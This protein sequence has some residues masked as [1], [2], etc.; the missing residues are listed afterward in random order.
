MEILFFILG[1]IALIWL[2]FISRIKARGKQVAEYL[3]YYWEITVSRKGEDDEEKTEFHAADVRQELMR[4]CELQEPAMLPI[5]ETL[6]V[7]AVNWNMIQ[8]YF[9]AGRHYAPKGGDHI[10]EPIYVYAQMLISL[11][12]D[13]W[14][15]KSIK[16]TGWKEMHPDQ[17]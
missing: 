10:P 5:L 11:D 3:G 12:E 8:L 17:L 9:G 13:E 15:I 2:C 16:K 7:R 4:W 1:G 6:G 14:E